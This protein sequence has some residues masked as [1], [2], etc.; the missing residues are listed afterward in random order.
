MEIANKTSNLSA[1]DIVFGIAPRIN[2]AGRIEH[3]KKAVEILIEK[4]YEKAKSL[5]VSIEE[6]NLT[7]RGLDQNITEEALEMIDKTKKSTVVF[8]KNL[9]LINMLLM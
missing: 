9:L 5:A 8:S 4:D 6:N 1:S 2:A 3:A 7:R